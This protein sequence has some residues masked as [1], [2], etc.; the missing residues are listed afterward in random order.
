M[1]RVIG[2]GRRD[3]AG[4]RRG[5]SGCWWGRV[6]DV[7]G[8]C[9]EFG[10]GGRRGVVR[11]EVL[12]WG[13]FGSGT[14]S[15]AGGGRGV[16][17]GEVLGRRRS[18]IGGWVVWLGEVGGRDVG[19]LGEAGGLARDGTRS[20]GR[21]VVET[22]GRM[23]R[24]W[25]ALAVARAVAVQRRRL[26]FVPFQVVSICTGKYTKMF[27]HVDALALALS[28]LLPYLLPPHPSPYRSPS[29]GH[30]PCPF[31]HPCLSPFPFPPSCPFL[32]YHCTS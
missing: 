17:G 23:G 7:G 8:L 31:S 25:H 27:T 1:G 19:M 30:A 10:D 5:V 2:V 16:V 22:T 4:G 12:G 29:P 24:G 6:G 20:R 11:G 3:G 28:S 18:V 9:R 14:G 32:F 13:V 26:V 15:R 21:R